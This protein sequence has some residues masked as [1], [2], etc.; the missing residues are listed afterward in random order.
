MHAYEFNNQSQQCV[1][2]VPN[3]VLQLRVSQSHNM[4]SKSSIQACA[5]KEDSWLKWG[6]GLPKCHT[7]STGEGSGRVPKNG[8]IRASTREGFR[9]VPENGGIRES[10]GEGSEQVPEKGLGEYR[11]MVE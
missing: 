10:I 8:G 4:Y 3:H 1:P 11:K 5:K 9:R 6:K 2:V 7:N